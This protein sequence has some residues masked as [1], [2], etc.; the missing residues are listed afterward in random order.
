MNK[1]AMREGVFNFK[2]TLYK[3]QDNFFMFGITVPS[4]NWQTRLS[5]MFNFLSGEPLL[6]FNISIIAAWERGPSIMGRGYKFNVR[7]LRQTTF[8][9]LLPFI[10][11]KKTCSVRSEDLYEVLIVFN[12]RFS[13][14][15]HFS[16]S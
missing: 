15:W 7:E 8:R 10:I 13:A 12:I 11:W 9:P 3:I 6:V 4:Y 14:V 16:L 5:C 1:E 2:G